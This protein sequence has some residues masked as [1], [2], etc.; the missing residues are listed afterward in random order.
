MPAFDPSAY[1]RNAT[2]GALRNPNPALQQQL[3]MRQAA[4]GRGAINPRAGTAPSPA[5]PAG[6]GFQPIGPGN[7]PFATQASAMQGALGSDPTAQAKMDAIRGNAMAPGAAP[8]PAMMD[9][10]R[11]MAQRMMQPGGGGMAGMFGGP[12]NQGGPF[13][14][15]FNQMQGALG[16]QAGAM[17]PGVQNMQNAM[18][19]MQQTPYGAMASA[20]PSLGGGMLGAGA[21]MQ[22]QAASSGT[23]NWMSPQAGAQGQ[24]QPMAGNSSPMQR[25]V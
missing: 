3:T 24:Q 7:N 9:Q 15:Q 20:M 6:G 5:A 17:Q 12:G 2:A 11:M 19:Q 14:Q 4:A 16:Q 10:Q 21:G 25:P 8:D 22:G 13:S 23:A 18:G 1:Q